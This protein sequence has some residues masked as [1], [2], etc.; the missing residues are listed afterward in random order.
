MTILID[1][2]VK[3]Q[4]LYDATA[5]ETTQPNLKSELS[6][7]RNRISRQTDHLRRARMQGVVEISLQPI[8][9]LDLV[10]HLERLTVIENTEIDPLERVI[11]FERDL[12]D[13]CRKCSPHIEKM[14]ADASQLLA[15][16][17][18]RCTER[19]DQLR[20]TIQSTSSIA[21]EK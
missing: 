3:L 20:Q 8:T 12:A 14:S 10:D 15:E 7:F 18:D 17:A 13:L 16:L 11:L 19:A 1:N 9:G 21:L 4:Q 2:H 6:E 5:A